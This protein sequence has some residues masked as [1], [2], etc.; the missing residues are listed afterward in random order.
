MNVC[1]TLW[2]FRI[3]KKLKYNFTGTNDDEKPFWNYRFSRSQTKL[4]RYFF[5]DRYALFS[6]Q[7]ASLSRTIYLLVNVYIT[8]ENHH[9][10]NG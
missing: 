1:P 3:L 8:M 2:R 4:K 7:I 9:A 5:M 6:N 10:I